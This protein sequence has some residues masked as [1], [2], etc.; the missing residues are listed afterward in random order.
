MLTCSHA[1]SSTPG[2]NARTGIE[3]FSSGT[4][5]GRRIWTRSRPRCIPTACATSSSIG[6]G[7]GTQR[8]TWPPPCAAI[9]PSA[10]EQVPLQIRTRRP[11]SGWTTYSTAQLPSFPRLICAYATT[12]SRPVSLANEA[13]EP[14]ST[15][16]DE[17]QPLVLAQSAVPIGNTGGLE[18]HGDGGDVGLR[19]PPLDLD[20]MHPS[21]VAPVPERSVATI[22]AWPPP[23]AHL[24]RRTAVPA[25]RSLVP[26]RS[27]NVSADAY[28]G[29]AKE[30]CALQH[31]NPF[32][33]LSR[34]SCRPSAPTSVSISSCRAL[35]ARF[36]TPQALAAADRSE[37]EDLIRSTG[38]FRSK[39]SHILGASEA[40]VMRH[41]G[42]VPRTMEELTA[43]PGVGRKTANVVLSVGFGLPGLPVDTH[44]TR[45]SHRLD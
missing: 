25:G 17:V 43:L 16:L 42:E 6:L 45:L 44:V 28:P 10:Y 21:R 9:S 5:K 19:H 15:T 35:F 37:L 36:P 4:G 24:A 32:E 3:A 40:I 31:H 8:C 2:R 38:F 20:V 34:P 33:L 13:G 41:G 11:P 7:L 27:E 14:L 23:G 26:A 29:S 18:K 22:R 30:L 39:A 1:S 12:C